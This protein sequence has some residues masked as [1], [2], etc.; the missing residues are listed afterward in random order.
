MVFDYE[1]A[2]AFRIETARFAHMCLLGDKDTTK[3][4]TPE[5]AIIASFRPIG[6]AISQ[7]CTPCTIPFY[8][9]GISSPAERPNSP[10]EGLLQGD[11]VLP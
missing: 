2:K 9:P 3:S 7:S 11:N 8:A 10:N 5:S 1:M 4:Y 6:E